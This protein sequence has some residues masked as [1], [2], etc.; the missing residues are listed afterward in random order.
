MV[1]EHEDRFVNLEK[2]VGEID[3]KQK[4]FEEQF[5]KELGDIHDILKKLEVRMIGSGLEDN[6][7]VG[8]ITEMRDLKRE[9]AEHTKQT[10]EIK[11]TVGEIKEQLLPSQQLI[12]EVAETKS[13]LKDLKT[14]YGT[15]FD[16][17]NKNKYV[18]WGCI[19][20]LGW[21]INQ[22]GPYLQKLIP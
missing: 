5:H 7:R 14:T 18:V 19:L 8:L 22:I 20:A 15:K 6:G 4:N 13:D 12:K 16:D 3:S 2:K 9:M 17:L 21:I 10:A 11:E 1:T